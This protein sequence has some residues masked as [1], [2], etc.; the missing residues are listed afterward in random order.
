[1]S[2][3]RVKVE[4]KNINVHDR[5]K[6]FKILKG[7]FDK[8]VRE[9]KVL[10]IWKEKQYFESKPRKKRRVLRENQLR[11]E[12]ELK[13]KLRTHFNNKNSNKGMNNV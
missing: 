7:M 4:A 12:K 6:A 11:R 9:S 13:E 5:D 10:T 1:M 8:E 2:V 3:T